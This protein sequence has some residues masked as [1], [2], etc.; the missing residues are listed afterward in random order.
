M[1]DAQKNLHL[2]AFRQGDIQIRDSRTAQD[3]AVQPMVHKHH[4]P[5]AMVRRLCNLTFI[6]DFMVRLRASVALLSTS[7]SC[8]AWSLSLLCL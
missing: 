4:N 6:C 5:H 3:D 7:L 2:D 1:M 8:Q